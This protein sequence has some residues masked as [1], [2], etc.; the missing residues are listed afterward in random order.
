MS[1]PDYVVV[2][3]AP[4]LP[5]GYLSPRWDGRWLDA[6]RLPEAPGPG[7]LPPGFTG[8]TMTL[9]PAGRFE[10]RDYDGAVA[11]VWEARPVK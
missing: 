8:V 4:D 1:N 2:R 3:P 6:S 7:Q 10:V 11:E 9:A 5:P